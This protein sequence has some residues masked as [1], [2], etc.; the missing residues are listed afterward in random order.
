LKAPP[1]AW[2]AVMGLH[3]CSSV[4]S[5]VTSAAL[6]LVMLGAQPDA[7]PLRQDYPAD[8]HPNLRDAKDVPGLVPYGP[9]AATCVRFEA[10]GLRIAL[11]TG[12]AKQ[13][14]GTGVATDFG[15]RGDFE[16][17]L[18]FDVAREDAGGAGYPTTLKLVVV[19]LDSPRP[20]FWFK[21]SQNRAEL[22]RITP[23]PNK[24]A[25]FVADQT[26]WNNEDLAKDKW[27]NEDLKKIELHSE[28]RAP[29][30]AK[31]G[32][33]RLVRSGPVLRFYTSEEDDKNFTLL[34]Q[35]DF[36]G[37]DLKNVRVLAS[38]GGPRA[39][40]DLRV[41][42]LRIRAEA[43]PQASVPTA[44]PVTQRPPRRWW[45]VTLFSSLLLTAITLGAWYY[46]RKSGARRS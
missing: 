37:K 40:L 16:I 2:N 17:T 34:H 18:S 26:T 23:A 25:V 10:D 32:R 13:R 28:Q 21:A 3:P 46:R 38:T 27:G 19:P 39:S 5:R 7:P 41:T 12:F 4:A 30:E 20:E 24:T 9:D 33:L 36:G 44:Q 42:D 29:T 35:S 11:P 14:S 31:K 6:A 8:F 22:G 45:Q 1:P 43:F 15:V